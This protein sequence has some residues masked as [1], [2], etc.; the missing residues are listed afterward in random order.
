MSTKANI[1]GWKCQKCGKTHSSNPTKCKN[2]EY[3]VLDYVRPQSRRTRKRSTSTKEPKTISSTADI[4]EKETSLLWN[5]LIIPLVLAYLIFTF[6]IRH[7]KFSLVILGLGYLYFG[8]LP[9]LQLL[10]ELTI[11]VIG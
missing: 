2:C 3:T 10:R 6:L 7:W 8:G 9:L 4:E 5:I 11:S 1:T